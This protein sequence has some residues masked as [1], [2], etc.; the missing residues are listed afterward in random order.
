[1][2]IALI[3]SNYTA[4]DIEGNKALIIR[5]IERA[6][7]AGAR[8]AVFAQ[9]AVCGT[10]CYS[11]MRNSQMHE[12]CEEA[13]REIACHC[14]GIAAIVGMPTHAAMLSEGQVDV[15]DDGMVAVGAMRVAVMTGAMHAERTAGADIV[16]V[17]DADRFARGGIEKR[18]ERWSNAT[19]AAGKPLIYVN[20]VGG[21]GDH[22]FDGSSFALDEAGR[23]KALLGSFE[24]DMAIVDTDTD[25]T[26]EFPVQDR[27][28]NAYRAI[29]MG[30]GDYFRKNGFTRACLGMSGGIDSAVVL[31]LVAEVLPRENIKVLMMPSPFSS[32]HSVSDSQMMIATLGVESELISITPAFEAVTNSIEPFAGGT[33]FDTTEENIQARLRCVMLM[34]LSNKH[35]HIVLNTSNKSESAVGYGTLYGD[36]SGSLAPIADL[37]KI[38]VYALARYINR[39]RE[40]IP[41][42]IILKAPSAELHPGQLDADSLPPYEVLDAILMRLIEGGETPDEVIG[43]GFDDGVVRR[44]AGMLVRSEYKRR[45]APPALK[46]SQRPF[47]TGFVLPLVGKFTF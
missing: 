7:E 3:Q 6:R 31:A 23:P 25:T 27:T 43:A 41:E 22:I 8:L 36:M 11:L 39:H 1:M 2:K 18:Y 42:N 4:G 34:A 30:L 19:F 29:K 24:E 17:L 26:F 44:I 35:G 10:P 9:Y 12:A 20:Q 38:D 37:Y 28:R 33:A 5:S 13:A 21:Q 16:V 14:R 32:G 45:Q 15:C 46:V 47:G 40:V